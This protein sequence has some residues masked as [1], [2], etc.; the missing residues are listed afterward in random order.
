MKEIWKDIPGY[1]GEYI[2]SE[3]GNIMRLLHND[4]RKSR[5]KNGAASNYTFST[6][7]M[8]HY[9]TKRQG[10]H[11]I[12][13][14]GKKFPVHRLVAMAWH[15]NPESKPQVNHIDHNKSN[16]HYSNLEWVTAKE[17]INHSARAGKYDGKH[18]KLTPDEVREIKISTVSSLKL[19]LVYNISS[20][21]IRH[22][23]QGII[24]KHI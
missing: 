12:V 6:L 9:I 2:V 8:K 17:N 20:S 7:L 10:Y 22:I 18:A 15:P 13:I 3:Y 21:V 1:E 11:N 16:N 5:H 24:W 14:K 23:R 4:Y 19:A